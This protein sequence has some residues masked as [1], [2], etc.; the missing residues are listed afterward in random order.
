MFCTVPELRWISVIVLAILWGGCQRGSSVDTER[1]ESADSAPHHSVDADIAETDADTTLDAESGSTSTPRELIVAASGD[2]MIHRRVLESATANPERFRGVFAALAAGIDELEANGR[3]EVV[4]LLNQESPLTEQY[5]PPYNANPPV[6]GSPPEL[7]Q[8]LQ[9]VG[10]DLLSFANN[11]A[12]DQTA[13]GLVDSLSTARAAG[14][15]VIGAA[16]DEGEVFEPL[17]V[18]RGGIRVG[19]LGAAGHV[20]GG[21]GRAGRTPVFVARL[22]DEEALLE[23]IRRLSSEVDAVVVAAHWSHDFV[24]QPLR[25]QR[26]LAR[27]MA[28]AGADVIFGTGP[29]VLQEV[30][31]L[32][33]TR[34]ESIVAY[35][36]GNSI[37]NQGLRYRAGHRIRSHEHPVAI[38]PG[39]RDVLLLAVHLRFEESAATTSPSASDATS[40]ADTQRTRRVPEIVSV[41][42]IAMWNHNN[43]W[44][45]RGRDD[46]PVDIRLRRLR[47][48]DEALREERSTAIAET[49]G[50]EVELIL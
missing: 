19:F 47:D 42:A 33:T 1:E 18:E 25:S 34:G 10:V 12:F 31:R 45:R 14:L 46:V 43:F 22:R 32:E 24:Q 27:E 13:A 16:V 9:S 6:L 39:T 3:Y 8:D 41:R 23:A 44:E 49:L 35:S 40:D 36:L 17:I 4:T 29:H 20:N 2:V 48:V 21:G 37:S 15:G 26:A 38:T 28:E 7:A 30:E 5:N 50:P 11:H